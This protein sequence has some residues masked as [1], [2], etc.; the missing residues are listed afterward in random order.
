MI[1]YGETYEGRPLIVAIIT[2]P[3]N[4]LSVE[5]IRKN[6]MISSGLQEGEEP[7]NDFAIVWLSYSVHGNESSSTEAAMETLYSFA[8]TSNENTMEWL[9]RT[10]L[11]IDPCMNPDGRDRY[12]Q[13]YTMTGTNPASSDFSTREHEEPWPSGRTNHYHFDLNRDWTWLTQKETSQRMKLYNLSLIHIW[14]LPT[15]CSV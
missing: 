9:K 12:V 1:K 13:F 7:E 11:I 10:V 2:H 5:D 3:D 4:N 14:T 15:I 8:N 6:H